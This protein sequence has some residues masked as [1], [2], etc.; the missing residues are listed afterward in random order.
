[1]ALILSTLVLY[2][3]A[4]R[5]GFVQYDDQQ[6]V[7]E[8]PQVQAGL[9]AKGVAWAFGFHAGNWH[10]LTWLSHELDCQMYGS[11]P[12]GHHLTNILLHAASALILFLA[13][14]R[15]TGKMWR[16]AAV[17]ALFAWHPLHVESVAWIAER[18]DVL[19][20]FF[21]MLTIYAYVRYVEEFKVQGSKFKVYYGLT[22][23]FFALCLM[24]KP[25]GVTLPFV[26]LLIDYWSGSSV[27][28]GVRS[29]ELEE[30]KGD[31]ERVEEAGAAPSPLPS[32][33]VG[34]R[35]KKVAALVGAR[36]EKGRSW[37][38]M[39]LEKIPFFALAGGACV[40]TV[41]AQREAI[42]TVKGLPVSGRLAHAALAYCHYLG[43]AFWPVGLGVYYPYE[44]SVASAA[45]LM[46]GVVLLGVTALALGRMRTRP[47]LMVGWLWY[48]GTLVPVIG[49]VQ[50]GDQAWADRYTYL[51]LIGVFIGVVWGV[52]DVIRERK[53]LL[54]VSAAT[55]VALMIVTSVQLSYWKDTRTLFEHTYK[56]TRQNYM[57]LTVL[58]SQLAQD[59]KLAEAMAD[60]RLALSYKPTFP[61]A[62]F[63]MGNALEKSGKPGEAIAEYEQALWFKPISEQTHIFLGMI[64]GKQLKYEEAA[65][66]YRAALK[67][68]P[69]S[70]V[71]HNNL[72]RILHSQGRLD[73]AIEH[74]LAALALDPKLAL[75]H[76]NLGILY[77]QKGRTA[78][79]VQQL[80]EALRLKPGDAETGYNLG[81]ALN[82]QGQWS[83]A[84]ELFK[85]TVG[86]TST[87]PKAHYEY[88]TALR[89]LQATREAMGQYANALLLRAD[90]PE[91]L[92]GLA[93]ILATTSKAEFRNG[94]EAVKMAE[95]A[96]EL[97]GRKDAD[98]L[99]T[100]AAAY[101]EAGRFEE[102]IKTLQAARE[103]A[104]GA[105]RKELEQ[106]LEQFQQG[107]TWREGGG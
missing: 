64:L 82:Q 61:E 79:G 28:C 90:F 66:H 44:G 88:A 69:D 40:L 29:A 84:A 51:P 65:G 21:W 49:L 18:K 11:K 46:A 31:G 10:P 25:M 68:N 102:A 67:I 63:F 56:V 9:S 60:Y 85:T 107:K 45:V 58:G 97:T 5:H 104:P 92:D 24:A 94:T 62:H 98:K 14:E 13:L 77:L 75:A 37:V 39:I 72:A 93:W 20:G 80:R 105:N 74:Y 54:T 43:A 34:A 47:Y 15:L 35:E 48:L 16:A 70:P 103:L 32:P 86:G 30:R 91:A 26:L 52:A 76:N 71:A 59:G 73:E 81:V 95:R 27:E 53:V 6:Y 1:M 96:C 87:D 4:L 50:V 17:A 41:L 83:E 55:A 36:A 78:E 19:C 99:R 100:L 3:P 2:L 38:R 57:A 33:P 106:M 8:N 101:A 89:H 7:T 23:G 22:L 42:V 12:W